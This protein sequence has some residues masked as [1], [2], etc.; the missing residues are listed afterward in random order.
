MNPNTAVHHF[1]VEIANRASNFTNIFCGVLQCSFLG[2]VLFF[3]CVN[4]MIQAVETDL[5][6][7]AVEASIHACSSSI[8]MSLK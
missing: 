5:Y 1:T 3:I 4:D 6:S 2:P 8:R 7:Y